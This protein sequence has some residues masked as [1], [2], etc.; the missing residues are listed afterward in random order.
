MKRVLTLILPLLFMFVACDMTESN[1][2]TDAEGAIM[3]AI[4]SDAS[5]KAEGLHD[6]E[7]EDFD[8]YDLPVE[9]HAGMELFR[10][11]VRDSNYVWNFGRRDMAHEQ[12]VIV[13]VE[14]D[15][16]AQALITDHITGSF[17]VRQ[18]E[19][20][21]VDEYHW[22]RGDSVRFSVKPI[23]MNTSQHV[24]F[25][26]RTRVGGEERW[27]PVA[28]TFLVGTAGT[29][30][31]IQ[32]IQFSGD[33]SAITLTDFDSEFYGRFNPLVIPAME[34]TSMHVL[35]SNDVAGEAE[36]VSTRMTESSRQGSHRGRG[37]F[38]Y[39][40]TLENGDKVYT[41][42]LASSRRTARSYMGSIEVLD[43]RTLFDHDHPEY[44][45]AT[46]GINFLQQRGD[47][48]DGPGGRP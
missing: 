21:W 29:T 6:V 39:V 35:V 12:E 36:M 18:F 32:A 41:K 34:N 33:D 9:G 19:R 26:K 30:L 14:D 4:T 5:F 13:E 38:V 1:S 25:K 44:S 45:A 28:R 40:E 17:H 11:T 10:R 8:L 31:D 23:D 43:M 46:L 3:K 2:D 48:P 7:N 15:T 47:R 27:I 37:Q 42:A 16:S 22:V 24:R 20:I